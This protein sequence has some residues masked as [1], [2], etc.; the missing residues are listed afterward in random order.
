[1]GAREAKLRVLALPLYGPLAA[2]T[3]HRVCYFMPELAARGIHVDVAPFLSDDYLSH[4]FGSGNISLGAVASGYFRRLG[5]LLSQ[6]SYDCAWV[7]GELNPL[8]PGW[9]DRALLRIPYVYDFDDAFYLKYAMHGGVR[10]RLLGRKFEQFI[11]GAAA[12][13]AGNQVL[14]THARQSNGDVR[15]VPTVVDH[16]RYLPAVGSRG[17]GHFNVGWIG[18]PSSI[19][20]LRVVAEPLAQLA[21]SGPVRLTVVGGVAPGIPGVDVVNLPWSEDTEVDLIRGFDVGIM[22]LENEPWTRGKCA[23]KLIQYMACGVPAIG[24]PVGANVEVIGNDAGLLAEGDAQWLAAL[25]RIR[26]DP[27]LGTTMGAAGRGKVERSYSLLSQLP[28]YEAILRDA[29]GK[30][31]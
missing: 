13:A 19:R 14:Q 16:R 9:L 6:G 5:I 17:T 21:R 2:S 4:R 7:Q 8:L 15:I 26:D 30:G 29:A 10:G 27:Q 25:Q 3:R 20:C 22:P 31:Q 24:S 1:M 11:A 12:V 18:S 28:A 23:F